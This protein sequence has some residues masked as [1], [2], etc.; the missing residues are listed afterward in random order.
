MHLLPVGV[1]LADTAPTAGPT[2]PPPSGW[3]TAYSGTFSGAADSGV[4]SCWTYD[5]GTPQAGRTLHWQADGAP[6]VR[7]AFI[8]G[9]T[10]RKP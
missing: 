4:D 10:E 5:T 6:T 7:G 9:D 2:A 3:T 8:Q 1:S